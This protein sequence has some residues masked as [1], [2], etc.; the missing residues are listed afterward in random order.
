MRALG[1]MYLALGVL[2]ALGAAALA[3]LYD[4]ASPTW[5]F[6]LPF[7]LLAMNLASAIAT[8]PVFRRNMPLLIFHLAL[9]AI[10]VLASIGRLTYFEG[11]VEVAT[12]DAFDGTFA[13]RVSGPWHPHGL[14]GVRF[15]NEGFRV[16]YDEHGRRIRTFNAVSWHDD[17]GAVQREVIGETQPLVLRGYRF[18]TTSNKGYAPAFTWIPNGGGREVHGRVHLP[19]YPAHEHRQART[20]QLGATELW[21]MLRIDEPIVVRGQASEFRVPERYRIIVRVGADRHELQPGDRIALPHGTLI[22]RGLG[23]WMGYAVAWDW[24]PPWLAAAGLVGVVG[25]ALHFLRKYA[26]G[27]SSDTVRGGREG[28][29]VSTTPLAGD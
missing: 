18:T 2:I 21:T 11:T 20:W 25:V 7:A 14:R 28:S 29:P 27:S 26:R 23:T 13:S 10:A 6:A 17:G 16:A 19:S 24:T 1:S 12:G 15:V 5:T 9:I 3:T 22:Y 4:W 8:R